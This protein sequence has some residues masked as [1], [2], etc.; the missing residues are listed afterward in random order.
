[1]LNT[2]R[3]QVAIQA[4]PTQGVVSSA[5]RNAQAQLDVL[6][7][8]NNAAQGIAG[9]VQA[10]QQLQDR[11]EVKSATNEALQDI[12]DGN[13][14]YKDGE[15]NAVLK[16]NKLIGG[17]S[18]AKLQNEINL[19]LNQLKETH[20]NDVVA[21]NQA[22]DEFLNQIVEGQVGNLEV[23]ANLRTYGTQ[24]KR[25]NEVSIA[26][27]EVQL[28]QNAARSEILLNLNNKTSDVLSNAR[29]GDLDVTLSMYQAVEQETQLLVEEG[30]ISA[31]NRASTLTNLQNGIIQQGILGEFD[32]AMNGSLEDAANYI[33]QIENEDTQDIDPNSK[34]TLLNKMKSEYNTGLRTLQASLK[35]QEQLNKD[36]IVLSGY[37]LQVSTAQA[38]GVP[39]D[40]KNTDDKKAANAT[41]DSLTEDFTLANP[42]SQQQAVDFAVTTGVVPE[43]VASR[44]RTSVYAGNPE[45]ARAGVDLLN[46]LVNESPQLVDQ[47]SEKDIAFAMGVDRLNRA[48]VPIEEALKSQKEFMTIPMQERKKQVMSSY[49][50]GDFNKEV[51]TRLDNFI[52][53]AYDPSWFKSQPEANEEMKAD[54]SLVYSRNLTLT[55]NPDDAASLTNKQL[56]NKWSV[57]YTNGKAEMTTYAPEKILA[58]SNEEVEWINED[59]R[60]VK[61]GIAKSGSNYMLGGETAKVD[62]TLVA[63]PSSMTGSVPKWLVMVKDTNGIYTPHTNANGNP[64][65]WTANYRDSNQYKELQAEQ[66]ANLRQ[67]EATQANI[68]KYQDE[69]GTEGLSKQLA[70]AR[71]AYTFGSR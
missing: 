39:L 14:A 9:A 20:K 49:G 63:D 30:E 62:L 36:A 67:A 31:E 57:T 24:V 26:N 44:I 35:A 55:G 6:K 21:Y 33:E 5:A 10:T 28:K 16:Y 51:N 22:S 54:Y 11:V 34:D 4:A 2:Y 65:Y 23:Q 40:Y 47:F 1:M 64:M 42:A 60:L 41:F 69:A 29:N 27:R 3:E 13:L 18:Q 71:K 17:A 32:S 37:K 52:D 8:F 70:N 38:T 19:G 50:T 43:K 68:V 25:G 45:V 48:G 66:E 7:N 56:S 12:A 15:S 58:N 61:E 59:L 46:R 53:E